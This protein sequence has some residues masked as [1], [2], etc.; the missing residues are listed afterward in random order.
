M[1]NVVKF[2]RWAFAEFCDVYE[3]QVDF[4]KEVE[5]EFTNLVETQHH[6]LL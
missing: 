6:E 4:E 5:A 1:N 2:G 3:M